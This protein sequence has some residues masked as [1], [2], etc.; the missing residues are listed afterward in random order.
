[1][2]DPLTRPKGVNIFAVEEELEEALGLSVDLIQE[3]LLRD[4]I[5]QAI[6]SERELIYEK[7]I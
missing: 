4:S 1:M 5:R 2:F 6:S 3:K 7:S